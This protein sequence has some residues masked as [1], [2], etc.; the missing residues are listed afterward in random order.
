MILCI[1]VCFNLWYYK[2]HYGEYSLDDMPMEVYFLSRVLA[3]KDQ[4]LTDRQ[5]G[6]RRDTETCRLC[7]QPSSMASARL[8]CSRLSL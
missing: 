2:I 3:E 5:T 7:R 8:H 4:D 6:G 1:I